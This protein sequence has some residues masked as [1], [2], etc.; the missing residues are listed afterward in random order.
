MAH[1]FL[2][3]EAQAPTQPEKKTTGSKSRDEDNDDV[4]IIFVGV[5]HVNEGAETFFVRVILSSKP[6]ISNIL[7]RVT[8]DASTRLGAGPGGLTVHG[9]V[10]GLAAADTD[11]V[12]DLTLVG[13]GLLPADAMP[14][15]HPA[16]GGQAKAHGD[17]QGVAVEEPA[18]LS[19]AGAA[20][21]QV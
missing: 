11:R 5:Q 13:A 10:D 8:R 1:L 15:Q 14:G 16:V 19:R 6:V 17:G 21:R 3:E 9:K 12:P 7:N 2:C 4:E 18:D 20:A